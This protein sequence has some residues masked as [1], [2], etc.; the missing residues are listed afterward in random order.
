MNCPTCNSEKTRYAVVLNPSISWSPNGL[1]FDIATA[2]TPMSVE[3]CKDCDIDTIRE[4]FPTLWRSLNR[5]K[6]SPMERMYF[7]GE[8]E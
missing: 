3:V 2:P 7:L 8:M 6:M 5:D 1:D 4:T